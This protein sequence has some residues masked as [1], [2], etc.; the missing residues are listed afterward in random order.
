MVQ[1]V[2][3]GLLVLVGV[4]A[5]APKP[6]AP[7]APVAAAAAV[8]PVRPILAWQVEKDGQ[9]SHLVGTCH[10]GI[11]LDDAV[12][13]ADALLAGSRLLMTE[14]E[15]EM[16]DVGL[17]ARLVF[18]SGPRLHEQ[19][20]PDDFRAVSLALRDTL[21]ITFID[22]M[23]PWVATSM[24]PL[25]L[26]P[27]L[28]PGK[29][30][31]GVAATG[32]MDKELQERAKQ[33]GIAQGTVETIA[34]QAELLSGMDELFV[35]S[36]G[37]TSD[38]D[39]AE[40]ATMRRL[41]VYGDTEPF[42]AVLAQGSPEYDVLLTRRN[43]AWM[44]TLLPE[45][46]RGGVL[47]AVGAGHLLGDDGLLALLEAEGYAMTRLTTT[48]PVPEH[49]A[50]GAPYHVDPAPPLPA[51]YD[52]RVGP[53]VDSLTGAVC[54][55]GQPVRD[56]VFPDEDQCRATMTTDARL[57][58]EQQTIFGADGAVTLPTPQAVAPCA[59]MGVLTAAYFEDTLQPG[60]SC[61]VMRTMLDAGLKKAGG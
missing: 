48:T 15:L 31:E 14:A 24:V 32:A 10:V 38:E 7:P 23:R 21:P 20:P 12:P 11:A 44:P 53:L 61:S 55:K 42:T 1:I 43:H 60:L 5:C 28:T 9:V 59:S 19:V 36:F 8:G 40:Q 41:C 6:V 34:Q 39:A 18:A 27:S 50:I 49:A 4:S 35:T 56:C 29:L 46:G 17:V 54:T 37:P 25:L 26:D 58:V 57:C 30:K 33:R 47:V 52:E 3:R 16:T 45:L 22:R 13:Q 2:S 51:D